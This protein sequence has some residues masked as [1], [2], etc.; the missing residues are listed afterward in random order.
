[1]YVS[2]S[3][4]TITIIISITTIY[5]IKSIIVSGLFVNLTKKYNHKVS[6]I[7]SHPVKQSLTCGIYTLFQAG[8]LSGRIT[9]SYYLAVLR[10]RLS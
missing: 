8:L 9:F 6:G 5:K 1:M 4:I 3:I 10:T 7:N 2:I